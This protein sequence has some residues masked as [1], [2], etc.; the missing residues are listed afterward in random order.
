M[1]KLRRSS[2]RVPLILSCCLCSQS[3]ADYPTQG[4]EDAGAERVREWV[5]TAEVATLVLS[6]AAA[7][8]ADN[9]SIQP[10]MRGGAGGTTPEPSAE[11]VPGDPPMVRH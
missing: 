6:G 5:V 8:A 11:L 9:A 10:P 4:Q 7:P 3:T 1:D 2:S